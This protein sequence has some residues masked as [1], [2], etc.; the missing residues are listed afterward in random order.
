MTLSKG[1]VLE[2]L[3]GRLTPFRQQSVSFF[4][5]ILDKLGICL[6]DGVGGERC[7]SRLAGDLAPTPVEPDLKIPCAVTS[8]KV[9]KRADANLLDAYCVFWN[10]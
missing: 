2:S 8:H 3:G 6:S 9:W 7:A 4:L 5:W 1:K 10:S